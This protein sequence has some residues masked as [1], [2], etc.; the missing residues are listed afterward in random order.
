MGEG[1]I[2][3]GAADFRCCAALLYSRVPSLALRAI[4]LVPRLRRLNRLCSSQVAEMRK[5]VIPRGRKNPLPFSFSVLTQSTICAQGRLT[6]E[7][8]VQRG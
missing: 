3:V 5:G 6:R 4:H 7:K 1:N 2:V 8:G